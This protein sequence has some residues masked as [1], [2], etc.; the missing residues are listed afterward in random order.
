DLKPANVMVGSF[1]E[2]Q[3]MDWGLAKVLAEGAVADEE[4]AGRQH[5]PEEDARIRTARSSGTSGGSG[6]E[7]E[8]GSVLGATAYMAPEQA[9]GDPAT[10]DRRADVFGLGAILCEV[11]TGKPPY[12]GQSGEEVHIKA[13]DGDLAEAHARLDGCGAHPDLVALTRR[14]LSP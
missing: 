11:L 10:L 6:P 5:R 4:R 9:T 1:G 12:E 8:D 2:V 13:A 3:V 7:T 14:C